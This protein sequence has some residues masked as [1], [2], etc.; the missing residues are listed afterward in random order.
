MGYL[1]WQ[2]KLTTPVFKILRNVFNRFYFLEQF[3]FHSKTEQKV[4]SSHL[5]IPN[6]LHLLMSSV[7]LLLKTTDTCTN[8]YLNSCQSLGAGIPEGRSY[9]TGERWDELVFGLNYTLTLELPS[10]IFGSNARDSL[11]WNEELERIQMILSVSR[12]TTKKTKPCSTKVGM[13][14]FCSVDRK[15]TRLNSSHR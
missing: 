12:F 15:S 1:L 13:I 5:F 2:A 7:L 6:M 9:D 8:Y 14:Q 10:L 4:Q 11:V 3:Q